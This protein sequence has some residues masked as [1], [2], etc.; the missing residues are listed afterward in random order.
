MSLLP[1]LQNASAAS[2]PVTSSTINVS[3]AAAIA[4]QTN[5]RRP[6]LWSAALGS[7]LI[8]LGRGSTSN[9]GLGVVVM[10]SR[11]PRRR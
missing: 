3:A 4:N 6:I 8:R 10:G 9:G 2:A 5:I 1:G 11:R 7:W